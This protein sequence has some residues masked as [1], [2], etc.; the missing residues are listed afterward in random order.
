MQK[1]CS[2]ALLPGCATWISREFAYSRFLPWKNQ[3]TFWK[4][5]RCPSLNKT[6]VF[7]LK[8]THW[9]LKSSFRDWEELSLT[10]PHISK[11]YIPS[12]ILLHFALLL[13]IAFCIT[14]V[15]TFYAEHYYSLH[16]Y[17]ILCKS[18]YILRQ[19]YILLFNKRHSSQAIQFLL[20][21]G[22]NQVHPKGY[23]WS[24]HWNRQSDRRSN[25]LW[26]RLIS[27]VVVLSHFHHGFFT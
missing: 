14:D 2:E 12:K 4:F 26:Q 16:Y 11:K 6:T 25:H 10:K 8:I 13:C 24:L 23:Q 9:S 1:Y 19:Y 20:P 22:K 5:S 15:I 7:W 18:H 27:K 17:Y 3:S 21:F